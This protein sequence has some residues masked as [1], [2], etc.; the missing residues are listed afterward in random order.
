[1]LN[2]IA[3]FIATLKLWNFHWVY[4]NQM[5]AENIVSVELVIRCHT[6]LMGIKRYKS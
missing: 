6:E 2:P 5:K 3:I 4:V 1:M